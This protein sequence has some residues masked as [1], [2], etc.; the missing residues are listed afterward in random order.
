MRL[1]PV[2]LK[3][4]VS[5]VESGSIAAA[6][7]RE[8]IAAAAVSKRMSELEDL[9]ENE[10]LSRT[11]K[12]VEPTPAGKALL[13]HARRVLHDLDEIVVGMRDW[14]RG[15]RGLV[16][17]HANISAITQFLPGE[18]GGFLAAHPGIQVSLEERISSEIVRGLLDNEAD[19]GVAVVPVAPEGLQCFAYR[20]D[21]LALIVPA[22][23]ELATRA[24]MPFVETLAHDFVGLHTGSVINEALS[25][26]A[27][28]AQ[29]PLRVRIQ[30]TSYDALSRMVQAGLG[31]GV[32]PRI[33]AEQYAATLGIVR[34]ALEDPWRHRELSLC[35]RA[36]DALPPAAR[37]LVD[38]LRALPV[39]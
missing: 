10:L 26:A 36:Y 38:H 14:T 35:M 1:D 13:Q 19:V 31:I 20:R 30:V 18:L 23:H 22:G 12:G 11:N 37:V 8:H 33:V 28:D 7:Q 2:S 6:A 39:D 17:V 16:R 3:L 27:L 15:T 34:I 9:L 5:V 32:M 21:E 25:R 24:S 4:F 29:R